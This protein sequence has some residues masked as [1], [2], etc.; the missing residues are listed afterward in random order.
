MPAA[1]HTERFTYFGAGERCG[2]LVVTHH[3][4]GELRTDF[5]VSNNGRGAELH[6]RISVGEDGQLPHQ[7]T[8]EGTS[9]MGGQVQ[10]RFVTDGLTQ[11]WTSQAEAGEHSGTPRLYLPADSSPYSTWIAARA[12]L[13]AGGS[14][15]ALPHGHVRTDLLH[16]TQLD[17]PGGPVPVDVHAVRGIALTPEYVLTDA[18]GELIACLAMGSDLVRAP[19]EQQ[20]PALAKL[21]GTLTRAYL[22]QVQ[23]RIRHRFDAPVRIRAVRVFDPDRLTLTEP[24]SV[25]MFRDR[26]TG[27]AP[28]E[29]SVAVAGEVVIDG[30]GGTLVAGLHDMH[31][32]VRPIDGLFYLAAG[33]TTVRDMGNANEALLSLTASWD[34]GAIA[35]PTVVPSGFIEGRSPHSALFGFIPE[36]LEE[37]LDAVRWYAARG[38]HQIKIYN[39]MNPDWVP[40][41]TAEAHRLGLRAVGHIPAFTTPD[42]MIEAGYDEITHVN[43]LMLGWLLDEG[44]DT[45]TPL[46]LT[47][48]TRAK[49]LDLDCD[50]VRH[51]LK[52]M[53]ERN[54]GLDTTAV[55]V[56]RLMLSR[57]RTVLSADAPFLSHMPAGYQRQRK[58]T[59]VPFTSEDDLSEYDT[60]FPVVLKVLKRLHDHGIALWPGTDDSTGFTVHRELELYVEAGLPAAEVLRIATRDCADHLGLGHSH[61][62]VEPGR[63]ASFVLLDGDP[64]EDISV[65]RDVRM[66]VKNGD[67]YYPHEIY[68]ELGIRP[69][70]TPP[71]VIQGDGS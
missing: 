62:R 60:S 51:T 44:E 2:E 5:A 65:V 41:L 29:E 24:M 35:G 34:T 59:Y 67:V 56:E 52:L 46:R 45:R 54:I 64:L 61:G 33:V 12:A 6:E 43:Q 31:A 68:T 70:S 66:V 38:Y 7:W 3:P 47:A 9:L 32:H 22:H 30:A 28:D 40:A 71:T 42:R 11:T 53:R 26:I 20:Y 39:S 16:S 10:E 48:M 8:V 55:I 14:V 19:F 37:A 57:A 15:E 69:F 17:G 21:E 18:E 25:T 23:E 1:G 58:R 50:A 27:M 13:A 49:D 63:N 36:T 4:D